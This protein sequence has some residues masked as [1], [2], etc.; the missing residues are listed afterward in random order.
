[1]RSRTCR[2]RHDGISYL[3]RVALLLV[4]PGYSGLRGRLSSYDTLPRFTASLAQKISSQ[5]EARLSIRSSPGI[6]ELDAP[7]R[8][9]VTAISRSQFGLRDSSGSDNLQAGFALTYASW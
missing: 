7:L 2:W 6:T 5:A 4:T 3:D 8:A 1:M 9:W